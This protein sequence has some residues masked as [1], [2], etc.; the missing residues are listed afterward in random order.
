MRWFGEEFL[1]LKVKMS[2]SVKMW[3]S[4]V[5]QLLQQLDSLPSSIHHLILSFC[6]I[7]RLTVQELQKL[8]QDW[9]HLGTVDVFM[10]GRVFAVQPR[11]KRYCRYKNV[12]ETHS[13]IVFHHNRH[14]T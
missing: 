7:H 2:V 8:S 12:C 4:Q 1:S 9:P 6:A 14:L 10:W 5:L 13:L 3:E 11:R